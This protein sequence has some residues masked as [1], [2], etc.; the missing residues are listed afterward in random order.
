[1][2][3]VKLS[4]K[5]K[6]TVNKTDHSSLERSEVSTE[7]T[8]GQFFA[9]NQI[10]VDPK[11]HYI[12]GST[13]SAFLD[14]PIETYYRKFG[15]QMAIY[16]VSV[17]RKPSHM[18]KHEKDLEEAIQKSLNQLRSDNNPKRVYPTTSSVSPVMDD[19]DE[20][21]EFL[22]PNKRV[23]YATSPSQQQPPQRN[24]LVDYKQFGPVLNLSEVLGEQEGLAEDTQDGNAV[25]EADKAVAD[26]IRTHF[27]SR[28]SR[29][30]LLDVRSELKALKRDRNYFRLT[31][32]VSFTAGFLENTFLLDD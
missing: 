28:V 1:M 24:H 16:K 13:H 25:V 5:I 6:T 11:L 14:E 3:L 18:I 2:P 27:Q 29:K 10:V 17:S 8:W 7:F 20:H 22:M 30:D 31:R 21:C 9:H 19:P 32:L 4:V 23:R 15:R 12:R 26:E